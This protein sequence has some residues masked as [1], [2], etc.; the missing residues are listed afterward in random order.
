MDYLVFN[1][2]FKSDGKIIAKTS[3]I[4]SMNGICSWKGED[5]E[6]IIDFLLA[7]FT[8]R[9]IETPT[10]GN[11]AKTNQKIYSQTKLL[12]KLIDSLDIQFLNKNPQKLIDKISVIL[13]QAPSSDLIKQFYCLILSQCFHANEN[14]YQGFFIRQL[15]KNLTKGSITSEHFRVLSILVYQ[16]GIGNTNDNEESE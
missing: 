7:Q 15:F 2:F 8:T 5:E 9:W 4:P 10:I 6:K 13:D 14:K 3:K 11:S 16:Y 12:C 1:R